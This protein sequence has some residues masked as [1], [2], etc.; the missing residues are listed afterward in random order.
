MVMS[1]LSSSRRIILVLLMALGLLGLGWGMVGRARAGSLAQQ[2]VEPPPSRERGGDPAAP[3]ISFIDSPTAQC[4]LPVS[5]TDNCYISWSYMYVTASTSQYIISMTVNIDGHI[6]AYHSGFFQTYMYVP[7]DLF[8]E[9]FRVAC[10]TPGTSIIPGLGNSYAYT[11]RARETGGLAA[12]N[13]GSVTCPADTV[14]LISEGISGP[15]VGK[16]GTAYDFTASASPITAT[17]PITYAWQVTGKTAITVTNG[18]TDTRNYIW[19]NPGMKTLTVHASNQ[20]G[21]AEAVHQIR[22]LAPVS[23]LTASNDGPTILGNATHLT[24]AVSGGD[25]PVF[26][27]DFGDG[28]TGNGPSATHTYLA[29]GVYVAEVRAENEVSFQTATTTVTVLEPRFYL[30]L[31]ALR[32]R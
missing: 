19:N 22:I 4:V 11:L 21:G 24:A 13:Y 20:A 1:Q 18:L 16:T 23:G 14:P 29:P 30:Y 32:S 7:G 17:V 26:T 5:G 31:P 2:P 8:S 3:L 27:W 12:A 15:T 9:G 6:R 10:G 25:S 28:Q